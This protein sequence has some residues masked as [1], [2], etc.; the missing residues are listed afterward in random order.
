[1]IYCFSRRFAGRIAFSTSARD[2]RSAGGGLASGA[3]FAICT[4]LK[5]SANLVSQ[6]VRQAHLQALVEESASTTGDYVNGRPIN[7]S[8][9]VRSPSLTTTKNSDRKSP[10]DINCLWGIQGPQP[11]QI[12]NVLKCEM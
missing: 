7:A 5:S 8:F 9:I 11:Q 6:R 3:A 10:S 2:Q 1:M 12:R 4:Q